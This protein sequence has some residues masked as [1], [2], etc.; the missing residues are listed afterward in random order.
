MQTV[1]NTEYFIKKFSAIPEERWIIGLFN[2]DQGRSCAN[3]HC[4][5][6]GKIHFDET[7]SKTNRLTLT[8]E[9]IALQKVFSILKIALSF[10]EDKVEGDEYSCKAANINNGNCKKYPQATPKQRI[11]AALRDVKMLEEQVEISDPP[12]YI[13]DLFSEPCL[14]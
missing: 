7:P 4:G 11:L 1:Y 9:S 10:R 5:V 6:V 2:D 8:L 14:A 13:K 12:V 3:G